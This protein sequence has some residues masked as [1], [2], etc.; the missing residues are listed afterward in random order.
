MKDQAT[1]RIIMIRPAKFYFNSETAADNYYQNFDSEST[2]SVNKKAL[3]EFDS[4]VKKISE[5]GIEVNIIQDTL[6]P[7]TP[8][9]IFSNN[10]F[11]FHEEGK[12]FFYP[13]FAKN[14]REE[15]NKFRTKVYEIVR[16][17]CLSIVD[18]SLEVE[19]NIFLEGTGSI[20]LDRENKKA[21]CS[22]SQRSN[23]DLFLI[24]CKEL[25]YRPI[26]FSSK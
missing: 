8:D 20:V 1:N 11:S 10:W 12:L 5:K 15:L 7:S 24:F 3:L 26:V 4:L 6:N 22:L 19:D 13:M 2:E 21:Y 16:R 25:G 17:K 9:S 23:K 14:R 18:Y